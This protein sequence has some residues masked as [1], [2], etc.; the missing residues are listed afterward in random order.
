MYLG[1]G[2][3]LG[4]EEKGEEKRKKTYKMQ[5]NSVGIGSWLQSQRSDVWFITVS[6]R[7]TASLCSLEQVAQSPDIL[8]RRNGKSPLSISQ[9]QR[10]GT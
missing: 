4:G 10:D 9:N 3:E 8:R 1:W 6:S 2:T 7:R 5:Y